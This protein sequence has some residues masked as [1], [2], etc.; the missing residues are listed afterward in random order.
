MIALNVLFFSVFQSYILFSFVTPRQALRQQPVKSEGV[1]AAVSGGPNSGAGGAGRG[2]GRGA[3]PS[4]ISLCVAISLS[5]RN[6]IIGL[7]E[8][9]FV[10]D[11][12]AA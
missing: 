3:P 12:Q 8:F 4:G 11:T 5:V 7:N 1:A 2:R 9:F 10:F 6:Q